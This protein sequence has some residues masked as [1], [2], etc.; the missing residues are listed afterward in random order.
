M[1]VAVIVSLLRHTPELLGSR[2]TQLT[3]AEEKTA[4]NQVLYHPT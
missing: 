3:S 4:S 1:L 2:Q